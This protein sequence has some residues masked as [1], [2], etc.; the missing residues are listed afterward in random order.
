[1]PNIDVEVS[2]GQVTVTPDPVTSSVGSGETFSWHSNSGSLEVD[3]ATSPFT[4]APPYS[5]PKGTNT[6]PAHIV[7]SPSSIG[8]F[9]YTVKV[10][11]GQGN[12]FELD[13]L[14]IITP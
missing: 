12:V 7:Q 4:P 2:G 9:K 6:S 5:A 10:T 14:V 1:M 11:D 8:Q 13:P 3:F